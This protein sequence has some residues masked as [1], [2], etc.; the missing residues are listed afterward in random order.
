MVVGWVV[1][2]WVGGGVMVTG[3]WVVGSVYWM[4]TRENT[5]HIVDIMISK[6]QL[7]CH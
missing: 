7:K 5:V 3:V 6:A 2:S 4:D 1:G